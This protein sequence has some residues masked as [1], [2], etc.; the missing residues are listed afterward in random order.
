[1]HRRRRRPG[2]GTVLR[3]SASRHR[4]VLA[5]ALATAALGL[6]GCATPDTTAASHEPTTTS[7]PV[8]IWTP[9]PTTTSTTSAPPVTLPPTTVPPP[10]PA[11]PPAPPPLQVGSTGPEVAA[12]EARLVELGMW[13]AAVDEVYDATTSQ[14]VMAFQKANGL[15]RDGVPGPQTTAAL[16]T[17]ARVTGRSAVGSGRLVE[18]DLERQLA[19]IVDDG[20]VVAAFNTSTGTGGR[21]PTPRGQFRFTSAIDGIRRAKL[22]DL[23]RPRYFNSGIA[24]HGSPSIPGYPASHGCARLHN[25]VMDYMWATDA[26]A[27]GTPVW[28]Y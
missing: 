19:L 25:A 22:G 27:I 4:A 23:Y 18:L 26:M 6:T 21:W 17:A 10:P 11:P 14:A 2:A 7:A 5:A 13:V 9:P 15:G 8:A 3:A 12:L 16:A 1:M 20:H 24:F 28:V